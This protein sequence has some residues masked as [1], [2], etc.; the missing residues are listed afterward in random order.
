MTKEQ[1]EEQINSLPLFSTKLIVPVPINML[2]NMHL[3]F[4]FFLSRHLY[5]FS[6]SLS[7]SFSLSVTSPLSPFPC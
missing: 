6:F 4:P 2:P 1:I 5:L 3:S 7:L